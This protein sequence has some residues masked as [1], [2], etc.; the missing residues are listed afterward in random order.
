MRRF[1]FNISCFYKMD[2]IKMVKFLVF[3]ILYYFA[4]LV[5][6]ITRF[7]LNEVKLEAFFWAFLTRLLYF[8][9]ILYVFLL[10]SFSLSL[11]SIISWS[12]ILVFIYYTLTSICILVKFVLTVVYMNLQ[13][14]TNI[15]ST[16]MDLLI[17]Y[18]VLFCSDQTWIPLNVVGAAQSGGLHAAVT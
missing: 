3:L 18:I 15:L 2:S 9:P 4:L 8:Y 16:N 1:H 13:F 7:Y 5:Y 10:D 11:I 6:P 12:T 14:L 17:W